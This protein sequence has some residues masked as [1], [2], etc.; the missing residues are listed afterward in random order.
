MLKI[1]TNVCTTQVIF[2]YQIRCL[3]A[4]IKYYTMSFHVIGLDISI[5]RAIHNLVKRKATRLHMWKGQKNTRKYTTNRYLK[6]GI[7]YSI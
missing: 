4:S 2:V 5:V 1:K 3:N 7:Y 6:V